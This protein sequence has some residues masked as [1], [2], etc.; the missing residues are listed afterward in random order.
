MADFD[1]RA[2]ERFI[3]VVGRRQHAPA[4]EP[5]PPASRAALTKMA[6]YRTCAPK[7]VFIYRSH[8]EANRDSER[9]IVDSIVAHHADG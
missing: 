4:G 2:G 7:G 9:W 1:P 5:P 3:R 8:E 6:A